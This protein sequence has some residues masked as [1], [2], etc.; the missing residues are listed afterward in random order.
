MSLSRK[1]E[2]SMKT[3]AILGRVHSWGVNNKL[4]FAPHKTSAMLV[5]NKL[6]Y[7]TPV[8]SMAGSSIEMVRKI[9][10]LGLT[11]DDKMTFN[12]HTKNVCIK[13]AEI[14]K[15]LS[16]A[17]KVDWGLNEEIIRTIYTAAVEPVI[18][19]AA[20][21]WAPATAKLGIRKKLNSIQRGFAQKLCKSYRTVSLNSAL[22]LSGILPLDLRIQ[23]AAALYEAR[24]GSSRHI[25]GDREI[26]AA[27]RFAETP[28]PALQMTL[29]FECLED[30]EQV[31][32]RNVQTVRI[33][34]D[35]SKIEGKVGAAL[36]IWDN[37]GETRNLKLSL[38]AYCTVYQAE[39][40]AI[41]RATDLILKRPEGSFG[42][43]SDSMS[44][45]MTLAN[46]G[47]LHPL[48]VSARKNLAQASHQ[49]KA[50]AL[51]WV[52]AHAG[53]PGNERADE[54]AKEA[55]LSSRRKPDYDRCPISFIRSQIRMGSLDEW[56]R[57]Y[58]SGE[59]ASVTKM[60]LPDAI[61][62][63]RIVK[64]VRPVGI[65]TQVLTGHGGFSSYLNRFKCKGNP[66]CICDPD[67]DEDIPH[68][69][70]DCP[71][72]AAVR[73]DL[74]FE[75]DVRLTNTTIAELIGSK[76]YRE[77]F[78]RYC[79]EV[80]KHAINRNRTATMVA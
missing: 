15:R 53:L 9:K 52:K 33:F 51:F 77:R 78:L 35:G 6:K 19:Y 20:A 54:L 41:C 50:I 64:Q 67:K 27:A 74:E 40:L 38:A 68:L 17:A 44:A 18:T 10:L 34:T 79:V 26:E 24:K 2:L 76:K 55:A 49:G 37:D 58:V 70:L 63:F 13:A 48:A 72:Y 32:S 4:R 36:S 71:V 65:V 47:S 31:D 66:S 7:D 73:Q 75:L 62:A 12:E 46:P 21:A 45:L 60:F 39:L 43:Y 59:T 29:E 16:R 56:N 28:H 25:P 61:A 11:I 30:Q 42:L 5:T 3:N 14:Y 8:L 80:A 23:E 1:K 57:R 69:L 22:V